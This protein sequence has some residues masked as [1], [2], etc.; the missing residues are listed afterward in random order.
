MEIKTYKQ[1]L[2]AIMKGDYTHIKD[3][4]KKFITEELC[5]E[6]VKRFGVELYNVPK[7]F[8]IEKICIEKIKSHEYSILFIPKKF[9]TEELRLLYENL[10]VL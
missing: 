8:D 3:I 4:P 7:E 1:A 10:W 9:L 2:K 5:I 6:S